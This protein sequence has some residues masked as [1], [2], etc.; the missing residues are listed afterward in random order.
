MSKFGEGEIN[1]QLQRIGES[2][3]DG[4]APSIDDVDDQLQLVKEVD[5]RRFFP[6]YYV[7]DAGDQYI[8]I[9]PPKGKVWIIHNAT[10]ILETDSNVADRVFGITKLH[11][12]GTTLEVIAFYVQAT[13]AADSVYDV[14]LGEEASADPPASIDSYLRQDSIVLAGEDMKG[15]FG[16]TLQLRDQNFEAGDVMKAH[17]SIEERQNYM[18]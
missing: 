5:V 6:L 14:Q 4:A 3:F 8:R 7:S 2:L 12:P 15:R 9:S 13:V 11:R 16:E 10:F 18:L 1:D 17:I